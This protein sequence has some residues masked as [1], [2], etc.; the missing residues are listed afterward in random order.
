MF[1]D[2]DTSVSERGWMEEDPMGSSCCMYPSPLLASTGNPGS[3][4]HWC[5]PFSH[6][7]TGYWLAVQRF[8][9]EEITLMLDKLDRKLP[10]KVHIH[11]I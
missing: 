8:N 6:Y 10:V 11:L 3:I 9:S 1:G 7:D 5:F 2:H 4:T